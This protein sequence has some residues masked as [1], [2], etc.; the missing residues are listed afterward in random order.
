MFYHVVLMRLTGADDPF[1]SRVR[2]YDA[3]V[4]RELPYVRDHQFG[5]NV[6]SRANGYDW[7]VIGNVR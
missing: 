3:R 2:E 4:R 6:A 7:A 1:L 5:R